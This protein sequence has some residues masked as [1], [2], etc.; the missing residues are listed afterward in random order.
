MGWEWKPE[1]K[2]LKKEERDQWGRRVST[3]WVGYVSL[4]VGR[5]Q[6]T[7]APQGPM[8]KPPATLLA[9]GFRE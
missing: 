2:L 3:C 4:T 6:E 5:A 7:E 1:E 9:L 8:R